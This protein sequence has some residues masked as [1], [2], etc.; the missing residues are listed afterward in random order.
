M[1]STSLLWWRSD[2]MQ[3]LGE[4]ESQCAACLALVSP[5]AQLID[6]NLRGYVLL[7]SA[8]FQGFC[9]DLHSEAT[10][11]VVSKVRRTSLEVL[12]QAQFS[13]YRK[14]DHG[15]PNLEN[16][17]EDFKRFGFILDLA[18]ADPA[19]PGRLDHL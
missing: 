15:N 5:P 9:R 2:R 18:A 7:L 1:P 17:R 19:N 3:R 14:L 11:I 12:F 8:H 6:E 4:V 10:Q 16:L 13:A